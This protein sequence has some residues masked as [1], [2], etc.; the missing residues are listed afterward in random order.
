L[1]EPYR[2]PARLKTAQELLEFTGLSLWANTRAGNLPI[3]LQ[4]RLEIARALGTNPRLLLLDEPAAGLTSSEAEILAELVRR[5]RS[6]GITIVVI[7]HNMAFAMNLCER[8]VVLAQGQMIAE[9][10]PE[11][12]QANESVIN[13]YLGH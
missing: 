7:E 1:F 6:Q 3:G 2:S 9:G 4:R 8:I 12:I 5:L 10:T 11:V 13:A